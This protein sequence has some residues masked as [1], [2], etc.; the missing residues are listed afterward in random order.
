MGNVA[1]DLTQPFHQAL[2][3]VEHAVEISREPIEFV[4]AAALGHAIGEAP[5]SSRRAARRRLDC[6]RPKKH[7]CK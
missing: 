5:H 1:R 7:V 6:R 3:A 4:A 2:N